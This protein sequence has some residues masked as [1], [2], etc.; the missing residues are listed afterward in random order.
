MSLRL[1]I[2]IALTLL[3]LLSPSATA[4]SQQAKPKTSKR[5][6]QGQTSSTP[7]SQDQTK[8][9][10]ALGLDLANRILAFRDVNTK[11]L[12][13]AKIANLVWK[14]DEPLARAL[15]EKSINLISNGSAGR[16]F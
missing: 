3:A 4:N 6:T 13:V 14:L 15:F 7:G 1:N 8:E 2:I 16:G 12:S 10:F 9:A 11:A 5:S